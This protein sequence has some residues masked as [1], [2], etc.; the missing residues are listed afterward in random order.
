MRSKLF[1]HVQ[2]M[3]NMRP[4]PSR[5]QWARDSRNLRFFFSGILEMHSCSLSSLT[6]VA[7]ILVRCFAQRDL[8][9][10]EKHKRDEQERKKIEELLGGTGVGCVELD[11]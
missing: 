3:F 10:K 7:E 11:W 6:H 5:N 4:S 1:D 2:M 9:R 8:Q